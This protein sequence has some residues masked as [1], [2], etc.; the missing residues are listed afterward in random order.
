MHHRLLK[1]RLRFQ[2]HVIEAGSRVALA[3][4]QVSAR[5]TFEA[6]VRNWVLNAA[7]YLKSLLFRV[8][9]GYG[10]KPLNVILTSLSAILFYAWI[11]NWFGVLPEK[12]FRTALYFSIVTFTTLGYGDLAP[13]PAYRLWA[14]SEALVGVVLSGLF[15]FTLAR[16]ASGRG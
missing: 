9:F 6:A 8:V 3:G 2:T 11:Y 15:L 1:K 10:E 16:R 7:D 14:G 4:A 13:K 12:G 5:A